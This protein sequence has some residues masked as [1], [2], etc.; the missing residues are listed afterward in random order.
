MVCNWDWIEWGV[1]CG[2]YQRNFGLEGS[3][4]EVAQIQDG[5]I[6]LALKVN[7]DHPAFNMRHPD[8]DLPEL[9]ISLRQFVSAAAHY[10]FTSEKELGIFIRFMLP[11]R[12]KCE[13]QITHIFINARQG[14]T[15]PFP[16]YQIRRGNISTPLYIMLDLPPMAIFHLAAFPHISHC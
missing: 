10:L 15:A 11:E 13:N 2:I 5:L 14:V 4:L 16:K 6:L 3:I 8:E 1:D 12:L 7:Y 9:Q